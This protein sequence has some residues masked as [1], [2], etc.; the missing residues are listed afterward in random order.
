MGEDVEAIVTVGG[1]CTSFECTS[2]ELT[3]FKN[4]LLDQSRYALCRCR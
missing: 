1:E 3:S 4:G 2:F